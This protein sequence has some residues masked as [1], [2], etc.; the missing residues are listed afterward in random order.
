LILVFPS[1]LRAT[2]GVPTNFD[3]RNTT[4]LELF[5][6]TIHYLERFLHEMHL[7]VNTSFIKRNERDSSDKHFFKLDT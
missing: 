6:L 3:N 4:T 1:K 2:L 5:D 7:V